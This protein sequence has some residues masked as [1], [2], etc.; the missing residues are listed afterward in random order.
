MFAATGRLTAAYR[1]TAYVIR[2]AGRDAVLRIGA[3]PPPLPWGAC[4][5]ACFVT[6]C[7]PFSRSRTSAANLRAA[8]RLQAMLR[9]RGLRVLAGIGRGDAG[10]WPAEPS[11][12]VFG[13]PRRCAASLGRRLRQNA[14][15]HVGRNK[16]MLIPLA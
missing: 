1:A 2:R 7:N 10:D 3:P 12:L 4:R 14:I 6:A 13:L 11:V 16:V 8:R 15:L 5:Q 9:R